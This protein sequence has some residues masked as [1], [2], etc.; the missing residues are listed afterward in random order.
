MNRV[1][2]FVYGDL[3]SFGESTN[4]LSE[5]KLLQIYILMNTKSKTSYNKMFS[6]F[7]ILF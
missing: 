4:Y 3:L 5:S 1:R 2:Q 7:K 6:L